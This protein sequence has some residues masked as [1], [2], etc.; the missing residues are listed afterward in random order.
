MRRLS[1]SNSAYS[2][3]GPTA[4]ARSDGRVHGVVVQTQSSGSPSSVKR[5]VIAGSW[6]SR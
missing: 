1:F 6:R 3:S 2:I 4:S 5:T